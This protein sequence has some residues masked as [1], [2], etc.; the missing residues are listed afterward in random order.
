MMETKVY[1][2]VTGNKLAYLQQLAVSGELSGYLTRL[3][4]Q[5]LRFL[6]ENSGVGGGP[7][8]PNVP[9]YAPT[10]GFA[11]STPQ[12]DP[13]AMLQMLAAFNSG[14]GISALTASNEI[15]GS[16]NAQAAAATEVP[17]EP[18][19]EP[20]PKYKTT[21]TVQMSDEAADLLDMLE[22]E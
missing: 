6:P 7:L 1:L 22:E 14:A 16:A 19:P 9:N 20:Q 15:P 2:N 17:T 11:P 3:V 13:A 10:T 4:E 5:D 8:V 18:E 12:F 21:N